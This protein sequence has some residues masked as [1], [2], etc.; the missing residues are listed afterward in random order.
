MNSALRFGILALHDWVEAVDQ[1][2]YRSGA[3]Y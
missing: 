2:G 1:L 3:G